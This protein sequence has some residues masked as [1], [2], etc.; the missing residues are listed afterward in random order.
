MRHSKSIALEGT[1][2]NKNFPLHNFLFGCKTTFNLRWNNTYPY[3]TP[4]LG[5]RGEACEIGF[6][7]DIGQMPQGGFP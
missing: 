3:A 2:S 6:A 4:W 7:R 1:Y 5:E